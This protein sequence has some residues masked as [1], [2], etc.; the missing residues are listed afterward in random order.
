MEEEMN[1][2]LPIVDIGGIKFYA[3]AIREEYT[4]VENTMN[5]IHVI[6]MMNFEDHSEFLFDRN[7]RNVYKGNHNEIPDTADVLYVWLRPISSTD[8]AGMELL[9]HQGKY[10]WTEHYNTPLP[11]IEIGGTDFYIDL[12]RDGFRQVDNRWN[13]ILFTDTN[14]KEPWTVYFDTNIK[15]VPF[16]HEFD[17]YNPPD[18]LPDHIRLVPLPSG[19]EINKML[20]D[21][22]TVQNKYLIE[23]PLQKEQRKQKR[24]KGI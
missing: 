24:G 14:H 9:I 10:N 16:R 4:E 20:K 15:N 8:P 23:R 19:I 21:V 5:S 12:I 13:M 6:E 11:V 7:T 1:R 18:K 3:N 2:A 22:V 17:I